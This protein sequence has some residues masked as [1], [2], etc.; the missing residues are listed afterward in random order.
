MPI[1]TRAYVSTLASYVFSLGQFI[2]AGLAYALPRWR[3]LQLLVSVPFYVSF[4]YSWCVGPG[5]RGG[6]H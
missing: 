1:H 6:R 4:L 3:H 5:G 2:L